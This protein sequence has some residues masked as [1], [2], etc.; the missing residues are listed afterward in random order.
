MMHSNVK[1]TS[2]PLLCTNF[3]LMT[4]IIITCMQV[5]V[6]NQC[7]CLVSPTL[8][9]FLERERGVGLGGEKGKGLRHQTT[10]QLGIDYIAC[11]ITIAAIT[12]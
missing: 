12:I 5:T 10:E 6:T 1:K 7:Q 8:S 4:C 9:V 11:N 2:L 3:K